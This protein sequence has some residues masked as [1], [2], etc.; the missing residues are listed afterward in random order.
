MKTFIRRTVVVCLGIISLS[1]AGCTF[2]VDTDKDEES[3]VG[4]YE[5]TWSS[6]RQHNTPQWF[7]D[8]K[9]GIYTHWG[10]WTLQYMEEHKD[11]SLD[12]LIKKIKK[13]Q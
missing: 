11:K 1:F 3:F 10:V 2:T 5:S 12:E 8:A 7:A 6:L 13:S 9:F 4:S